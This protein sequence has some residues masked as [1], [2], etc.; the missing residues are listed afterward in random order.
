VKVVWCVACGLTLASLEAAGADPRVPAAA[1]PVVDSYDPAD[2]PSP[3]GPRHAKF[4]VRAAFGPG[5]FW[6]RADTDNAADDRRVFRGRSAELQLAMGGRVR[7]S[8]VIVGGM[9]FRTWVS[10][11]RARDSVV[12][13]DEPDLDGIDMALSGLGPFLDIYFGPNEGTHVQAQVGFASL[14]VDGPRATPSGYVAQVGFGHEFWLSDGVLVGPLLS[15]GYAYLRVDEGGRSATVQPLIPA[16]LVS[17]TI[18]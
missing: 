17:G 14:G 6:A 5:L 4:Y 13:G 8:S 16:L 18:N 15:L 1:E 2:G 12:D 11:L 10:D 3:V 9:Y 7:S